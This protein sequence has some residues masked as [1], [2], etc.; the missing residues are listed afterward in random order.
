MTDRSLLGAHRID[1]LVELVALAAGDEDLSGDELL[2]A[3]HEQADTVLM[4]DDRGD[5]VSLG[6]GRAASGELV[7]VVRLLVVAPDAR[8]TGRARELLRHAVE[9]AAERGAVRLELGGA[10]PFAL[11]P[12]VPVDSAL[13]DLASAEGFDVGGE[14]SM[15]AV[16]NRFRA[17]QPAGLVIRR[18][19]RDDDV[20]AV[21]LQASARWPRLSDEIARALEHGTCHVAFVD[22]TTDIVGLATHSITRATWAGP[23][24]VDDS[25][26]RRGVG[27][28]LLGQ[29]CRDL[30]IAEFPRLIVAE[31]EDGAESFLRSA[32]ATPAGAWRRVSRTID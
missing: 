4:A 16:P 21:T 22:G 30:M 26:R 31:A 32:G 29:L 13:L 5:A 6:V 7:A 25:W 17:E 10:L 8:R 3:C 11:W 18:A 27:A 12:G 14:R 1:E 19:V 2:T 15:W 9:W 28:A 23:I 20:M 24:V